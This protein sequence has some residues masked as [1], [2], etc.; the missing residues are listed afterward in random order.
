VPALMG[1]LGE[2]AW[3]APRPLRAVHARIGLR[4]SD[5]G[6]AGA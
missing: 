2:R 3:W 1:R 4:E 6:Q 5:L